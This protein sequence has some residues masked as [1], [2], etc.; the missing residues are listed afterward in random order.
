MNDKIGIIGTGRLGSSLAKALVTNGLDVRAV[1]NRNS[2][3]AQASARNCG[4]K[5]RAYALGDLPRLDILF[6]AVQDDEIERA[7]NALAGANCLSPET[8]VAHTS[9][10]KNSEILSPLSTRTPLLA[11]FHPAQTF[12]GQQDDWKRYKNIFYGIEGHSTAVQR[13]V[14]IAA[15]LGGAAIV[16]RAE[17]KALYHLACVFASNVL[18]AIQAMAVAILGQAGVDQKNSLDLLKP[19]VLATVENIFHHGPVQAL[20]GPVARS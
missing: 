6:I 12:S 13:L 20:T 16:I 3:K 4:G 1:V 10:V 5:V 15:Q 11:S 9:G 18:V 14:K 17:H 2:E 8:I 19:L 7:A